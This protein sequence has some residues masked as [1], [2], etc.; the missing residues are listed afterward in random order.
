MK[1]NLD[2]ILFIDDDSSS[3]MEVFS[4]IGKSFDFSIMAFNS[5]VTGIDYLETNKKEVGAVLLDLSFTPNKYEGVEALQKIKKIDSFL[6]V[7][8]LTGTQSEKKILK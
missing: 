6:P 2:T 4:V 7:I 3:L 1:Q 8:M 5:V